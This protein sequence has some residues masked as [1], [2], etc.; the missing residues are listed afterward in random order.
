MISYSKIRFNISI[1]KT[2]KKHKNPTF[3]IFHPSFKT[4]TRLNS[5]R[6]IVKRLSMKYEREL[7]AFF[8]VVLAGIILYFLFQEAGTAITMA[9]R[10]AALFGYFF[11]FMEIL[12]SEYN[13]RMKKMLGRPFINVHHHIARAAVILILLH[14]ILIAY[15]FGLSSFVPVL[16]PL[17]DFLRMAGR[18][19]LYLIL[20]AVLAGVY[21]KKIPKNWRSIH[22]LNYLGFVLIFFH[23]WLIGTDLQYGLM[24]FIWFAMALIVL[25]VFIHKHIISGP[26]RKKSKG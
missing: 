25:A 21:R 12:S 1:P 15:Q 6:L 20:I 9:V 26:G 19:A 5:Y 7:L 18:P 10:T 11:L 24:Q 17:I 22:E 8:L 16:Y 23:A 3:L 4:V 2:Q 13:I 14:P